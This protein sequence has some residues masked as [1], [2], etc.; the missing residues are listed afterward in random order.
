MISTDTD[1]DPDGTE[2]TVRATICDVA[3]VEAVVALVLSCKAI[4]GS[5]MVVLSEPQTYACPNHLPEQLERDRGYILCP[6]ELCPRSQ[7]GYAAVW[8]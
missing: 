2:R 4:V 7:P 3:L 6:V 8:F 5:T 1:S